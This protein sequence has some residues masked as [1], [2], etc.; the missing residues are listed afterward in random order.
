[1][2]YKVILINL[3]ITFKRKTRMYVPPIFGNNDATEIRKFVDA[4]SFAVLVSTHQS[5]LTATHLP[6]KWTTNQ[7]G[8]NV[9]QGHV[10]KANV[11]WKEIENVPVL[12]IFSGPHA[13]ISSSWY[14]HENVPTWNY[15]AVHISG[16]ARII[17]GEELKESLKKLVDTYEATSK[18]PISVEGFS[19][20]FY[21]K[22]IRGLVGFEIKIENVTA[23]H[24]LSQNRDKENHQLI[25]DALEEQN[26]PNTNEIAKRMKEGKFGK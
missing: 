5:V 10:A 2:T 25:V 17:E 7:A 22:N 24:K 19:E 12:A 1:M 26:T 23:A 13:Y 8:E 18:N 20:G 4:N 16:K 3:R 15:V 21:E 6:L 11:Q 14:N 9:L